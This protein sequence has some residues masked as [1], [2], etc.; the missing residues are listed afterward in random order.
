VSITSTHLDNY[1]LKTPSGAL[2]G[3]T[4]SGSVVSVASATLSAAELLELIRVADATKHAVSLVA[5]VLTIK[6]V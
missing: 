6:P 2:K 1:L 3:Y 4:T 5:G